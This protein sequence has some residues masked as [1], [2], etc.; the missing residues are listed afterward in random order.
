MAELAVRC[1][2]M[3]SVIIPVFNRAEM[4]RNAVNSAIEQSWRPIEIIIVDDGSTDDTPAVAGE[5]ANRQPGLVRVRRKAN[6]GPGTAREAGRKEASGEFIQYLDSDDV[7]L[8]GKFERQVGGLRAEPDCGVSYGWTRYR[9]AD[10]RVEA[11]PWKGSGRRV[12][13][14]FPA[15]LKERW[16]DTPTPL[17]RAEVLDRAGPWSD[18]RLEEDW[19]Y[20]TRVA[21]LGVR[22]H[23]CEA[24]VAEVRDHDEHRLC[25]GEALDAARLR[26]RAR[27]H[28]M[29]FANA[30]QYG[31]TKDA[32]E[33]QH[34]ARELFLLA[35][36]SGAAALNL[37][38]RALF[39]LSVAASARRTMDLV[40]YRA[41]A[42]VFG[43]TYAG[44]VGCWVD[45]LRASA[46]VRRRSVEAHES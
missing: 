33:M 12:E 7:L 16:W 36:Q 34:F 10:G 14:M 45:R 3:V 38:A 30:L 28:S 4:L 6:G 22:L 27:A 8:P 32:Q 39:D 24:Y 35:R 17:Y 26:V 15:M 31:I 20:D 23:Y 29:I 1:P 9:H 44:R 37:E 25:R 2:G 40:V 46:P 42:A 41:A 21:A 11:K 5:L 13:W 19:E 43:W 18:L